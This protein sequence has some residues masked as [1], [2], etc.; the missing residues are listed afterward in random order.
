M[1]LAFDNDKDTIFPFSSV[2]LQS[3]LEQEEEAKAALLGR[4]QRLT[5]LILVSTKASHSTRFPNRPGPRRRHSFGE[6]EGLRELLNDPRT[7]IGLKRM[8][9]LDN[10]IFVNACKKKFQLEEGQTKGAVL[11]SLWQE[12]L[13]N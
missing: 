6:E 5:K 13:K 2:K 4:I 3:R 7:N 8:G 10:K 9:K 11:C 12:N 1:A